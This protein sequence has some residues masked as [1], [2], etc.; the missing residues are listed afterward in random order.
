MSR[1]PTRREWA[2]TVALLLACTDRGWTMTIGVAVSGVATERRRGRWVR[3]RR[4]W[5]PA[6]T[7][8]WCRCRRCPEAGLPTGRWQRSGIS[9]PTTTLT[10]SRPH[11]APRC[12]SSPPM[13][14]SSPA[15]RPSATSP[16]R[17][18]PSGSRPWAW[19]RCWR[20]SSPRAASRCCSPTPSSAQSWRRHRLGARGSG[21]TVE[22]RR[23]HR[24]RRDHRVAVVGCG[25]P[26]RNPAWDRTGG[27]HR[28][29]HARLAGRGLGGHRAVLRA[30][31]GRGEGPSPRPARVPD[32]VPAPD[33]GRRRLDGEPRR[34]RH[35]SGVRRSVLPGPALPLRLPG[36]HLGH[37]TDHRDPRRCRPGIRRAR[38]APSRP[39]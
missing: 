28:R 15:R 33:P 38:R 26:H 31:P 21:P 35:R 13:A 23:R 24:Q 39:R 12:R 30:G 3:W 17:R 11:S 16:R 27:R 18:G 10:V 22:G 37:R 36:R 2:R 8:R 4:W 14:C 5:R 1:E 25:G 29:D 20:G 7:P 6:R 32:R 9:V 19:W 34:V